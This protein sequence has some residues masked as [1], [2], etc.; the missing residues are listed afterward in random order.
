MAKNLKEILPDVARFLI[1]E[2]ATE[3][4]GGDQGHIRFRVLSK[5]EA[6]VTLRTPNEGDRRLVSARVVLKAPTK[7]E[8]WT[9][10]KAEMQRRG[11]GSLADAQHRYLFVPEKALAEAKRVFRGN[12]ITISTHQPEAVA[13]A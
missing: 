7:E 11:F 5:T 10:L 3:W 9:E 1:Q 13:A 8:Q 2:H 6:Y 12:K 4:A